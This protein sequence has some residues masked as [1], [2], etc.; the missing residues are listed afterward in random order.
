VNSAFERL[1]SLSRE[2]VLGKFNIFDGE[3]VR[4]LG[5]L[6]YFEKAFAGERVYV[7]D[8]KFDAPLEQVAHDK[9]SKR[10]ISSIIYPVKELNGQVSHVAML[11]EDITNR[12]QAKQQIQEYQQRL[13]A[14]SYQ[15]TLSEERERRRI[16]VELHDHVGQSLA[17]A[18]MRLAFAQKKCSDPEM[19]P[20][21]DE[22]SES[23][24]TSIQDTRN[25]VFDLSSPLLHEIG[26]GEAL[27][28]WLEQQVQE[29][30]GL[31]I[32]ITDQAPDIRLT[33]DLRAIL[34][35]NVRELLT[36]VVK[37]ANASK[38][39]VQ[40]GQVGDRIFV[41]V[42]DDGIG[43]DPNASTKTVGREEG[44]GLFSIQ[45]RMNDLGGDFK[46]ESELGQGTKAS[47]S[48]PLNIQ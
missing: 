36:N 21:L 3:R 28:E 6:P 18:R 17:F 25:L 34:F 22:I 20:I 39:S 5:F 1:W 14:L 38:V 43:F 29:R 45:E 23:L 19:Q 24:L 7:S 4:E 47:L 26:F 12:V 46:I 42:Q 11:H 9:S 2:N 37:H 16:A 44:F 33:D 13:K 15:L 40:L 31:E 10:W 27:A 30:Y 48:I 8:T 35:R 32:E 41:I